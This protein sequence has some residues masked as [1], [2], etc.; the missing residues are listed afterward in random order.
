MSEKDTDLEAAFEAGLIETVRR[1]A[2]AVFGANQTYPCHDVMAMKTEIDRLRAEVA[3]LAAENELL[4]AALRGA[5]A[6]W[7]GIFIEPAPKWVKDARAALE[8]KSDEP[9]VT[10]WQPIEVKPNHAMRVLLFY[11]DSY[12]PLFD[13]ATYAVEAA[14]FMNGQWLEIG[15]NHSAFE[16]DTPT[17]W[18][19]LPPPPEDKSDESPEGNAA[20]EGSAD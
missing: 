3:R 10:Q 11:P 1:E 13:G 6:W 14:Y 5:V 4:R 8:D 16:Y 12:A 19:P 20:I 9:L 17:H 15:T 7:G 2:M 18:M